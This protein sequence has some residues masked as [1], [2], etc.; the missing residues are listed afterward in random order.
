MAGKRIQT[1]TELKVYR[2]AFEAGLYPIEK[3]R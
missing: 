3:A 2:N 1:H